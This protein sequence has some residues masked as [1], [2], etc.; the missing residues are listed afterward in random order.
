MTRTTF[1]IERGAIWDAWVGPGP[2]PGTGHQLN[3]TRFCNREKGKG[4]RK[5]M[6]FA[7]WLYRTPEGAHMRALAV[8]FL[9]GKRL[10]CSDRAHGLT[11]AYAADG[12][13]LEEV[14]GLLPDVVNETRRRFA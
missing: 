3:A 8:R 11:L 4:L 2:E 7:L 12:R 9:R 14:L 5:A 6:A 13:S 10:G 1:T